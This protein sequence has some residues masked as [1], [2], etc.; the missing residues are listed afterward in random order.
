MIL[1]FRTFL[2]LIV[3]T[4]LVYGYDTDKLQQSLQTKT[5]EQKL[6][7]ISAYFLGVAY[8]YSPLGEGVGV[9]IDPK[10]RLDKFDCTTFVETM[11]ALTMSQNITQSKQ[12]LDQIRYD[13]KVGF[14]QRRHL[15]A[16]MWKAQ[17]VNIGL[18][19]DI[20]HDIQDHKTIF[21]TPNPKLLPKDM[22]YLKNSLKKSYYID[23]IPLAKIAKNIRHIP[24]GVVVNIVRENRP[25]KFLTI[26][27]QMLLFKKQGKIYFRHASSYPKRQVVD[28]PLSAFVARV[29]KNKWKV[30]GINILKINFDFKARLRQN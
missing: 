21:K 14:A 9:D 25:D 16:L 27:H 24:S 1:Y 30:V 17:L 20:T 8:G 7:T 23:Y 15:P 22:L 10:F 26:T 5:N 4:N 13:G 6:Q 2:L 3:S 19:E 12:T 29:S 11:T 28:E 18:Y